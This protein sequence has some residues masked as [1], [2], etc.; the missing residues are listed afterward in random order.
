MHAYVLRHGRHAYVYMTQLAT[1]G[2]TTSGVRVP[3]AR[4][5][6]MDRWPDLPPAMDLAD[7]TT[8]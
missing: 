8:R 7:P 1:P 5:R 2:G 3:V 6:A 4:S